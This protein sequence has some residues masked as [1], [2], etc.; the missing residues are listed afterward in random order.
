MPIVYACV[1]T[2]TNASDVLRALANE[3]IPF[4]RT[5]VVAHESAFLD[6][7]P[8]ASTEREDDVSQR[9]FASRE[10]V[11]GVRAFVSGTCADLVAS[12]PLRASLERNPDQRLASTLIATGLADGDAHAAETAVALGAVVVLV[13][14]SPHDVAHAHAV[15]Q[16]AN[17]ARVDLRATVADA[18]RSMRVRS[19]RP[20]TGVSPDWPRT[21]W[22]KLRA[23]GD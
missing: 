3:N 14:V 13:E 21:I 6:A 4:V 18:P 15:V 1:P 2:V 5:S 23:G 17:A 11:S 7:P 22:E 10:G 8:L 9:V 20:R 16:R 19:R 12:G